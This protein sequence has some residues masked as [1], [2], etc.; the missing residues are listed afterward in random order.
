MDSTKADV[1]TTLSVAATGTNILTFT[2]SAATAKAVTVTGAGSVNLTGKAFT[3]AL[4]SFDASANTGGV[5]ADIQSSATAAV[6][7][8]SGN[9][10]FDMDT[11]VTANTTVN[12]G[13]GN[14]A[15]YVGAKLASFKSIAG[16]EGTD[17]IIITDA[18]TWTAANSKLISGF[19]T[20]DVSGGKGDYD[21]SLGG[22]ETVQI[23]EAVNGALSAATKLINA[24][25][26]F[27]LNVMSKAKTNA[28]FDL[29][30]YYSNRSE[31]CYRQG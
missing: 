11:T 7:G 20:L 31:G 14:D 12:L 22:F 15:I 18:A 13:A 2:D 9:D 10:V 23:D 25:A 30:Q 1:A 6:K 26:D 29:G 28:D 17:L 27:T 19:E 5:K 16:G 24:G 21:V 4:T 3:A 8:G